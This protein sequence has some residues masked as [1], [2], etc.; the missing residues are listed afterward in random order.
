M[1]L[2][3]RRKAL[4]E[5]VPAEHRAALRS[6]LQQPEPEVVRHRRADRSWVG[7]EPYTPEELEARYHAGRA[8]WA[9][10]LA[11][12]ALVALPD[13]SAEQYRDQVVA[14]RN[15]S[16]NMMNVPHERLP[17][18]SDVSNEDPLPKASVT[19]LAANLQLWCEFNSW[20]VCPTCQ[21]L[22]PR[23]LTPA[24]LDGLLEP[25]CGPK[26][27]RVC[28]GLQKPSVPQHESTPAQLAGLSPA[29]RAALCP[30]EAYYGPEVRARDRFGRGNGYREHSSMVRF[31]WHQLSVED[32]IQELSEENRREATRALRWL[33]RQSGSEKTKSAYGEFYA[34]HHEFLQRTPDATDRQR[35]RWLRFLEREGLECALWPDLFLDRQTC[36]TWVRMQ[37]TSRQ[38]AAHGSTLQERCLSA[39][40]PKRAA[41]HAG[42][43]EMAEEEPETLD[44]VVS[45][46]DASSSTNDSSSS[47]ESEASAPD[48]DDD[49]HEPQRPAVAEGAVPV[50]VPQRPAVAACS[51][52]AAAGFPK[53]RR[54]RAK[55]TDVEEAFGFVRRQI[56]PGLGPQ[57]CTFSTTEPNTAAVLQ[58][59]GTC[60]WCDP[61]ALALLCRNAAGRQSLCRDLRFFSEH[62]IEGPPAA[63]LPPGRDREL[64]VTAFLLPTAFR[65]AAATAHALSTPALALKLAAQLDKCQDAEAKDM[66]EQE[67]LTEQQQA[68]LAEARRQLRDAGP[69]GA[70]FCSGLPAGAGAAAVPCQFGPEGKRA[71]S[72]VPGPCLFCDVT[73]LNEAF[74]NRS[75][76]VVRARYNKLTAAA[77]AMAVDRV[78]EPEFRQ[79]LATGTGQW[80]CGG[81]ADPREDCVFALS[82]AAAAAQTPEKKLRC[83]FCDPESM[84]KKCAKAKGLQQVKRDLLRMGLASRRKALDERVPAEHRAALRSVLQQPEP[85]VVR[86]RRADRSW[87]GTE[88][89]TPEE[90]EARYHAGRAKWAPVL[91]ARALV[92]LPDISAEQYR[93]QVVADRN[94]S[95]NMMNVPHERLPRG[96][97]VSNEDP[98]PKASVTRLAANLQLWCEF[99]SW[100][101]CP[102]CQLLQPRVLTPA[103]LDGLLE[104]WCGPKA[105]RVCR[106]LQK[107]SVPQHESTPAQLAGL[108]PAARAALCPVEAYYGP[109][110]RAKDRFG[111]GN[112]YREHSSM[113]RFSWHQLSVEDR[114]QEL[115]EENRREAT[116]ALRWLLRQSGS[117]KTK[118]AYGE[119]YAEHHEFLQRT[120]D[121]TER[122]RKRWLRFLEREGLECALWPDLFLDRQTC[123]TWVRMQSTS[124][125]VAA[126]GSTLQERYFPLDEA[127]GEDDE[128][129]EDTF[130]STKRAYIALVLSPTLDYSCSYELLHFAYDLNLWTA[131]GA[132]KNKG[133]PIPMRLLMRGHSFSEEFWKDMHRALVDLVRQN[134]FPPVFSTR[135]PLE[136]SFPYHVAVVNTMEKARRGRMLLPVH[137]TLHQTHV[138]TQVGLNFEGGHNKPAERAKKGHEQQ[139]LKLRRPDGGQVKLTSFQRVEFQD[140]KRKAPTQDYHGSGRAH[141]H[142]LEFVGKEN[143]AADLAALQLDLCV[144]ASGSSGDVFVDGYV[145]ASQKDRHGRTPWPLH[146]GE[147]HFDTE[148]GRYVLRHTKQDVEDGIRGYY[149]ATMAVTKC[150][151]DVQLCYD[152]ANYTLYTTAYAPKFSDSMRRE[153]L[154]D[155]ADADSIA[156][157]VLMRYKPCELEMI[158]QLFGAMFRQW[159]VTT[160]SGGKRSFT[161]PVPDNPDQP[162]EVR[163]YQQCSWR[164]EDM[165]MLEFLRKSNNEGGICGWL[166]ELHRKSG[167]T[168]SLAAF[169]NTYK[170][171]GEKIV[172]C[173]MVSRMND[174]Y[175][176]QWLALHVPFRSVID[177]V[178]PNVRLLVPAADK[179]LGMCLACEH[180]VARSHWH[181][182]RLE[183]LMDEDMKLEART[184][185]Y[186]QQVAARLAPHVKKVLAYLEGT[187]VKPADPTAQELRAQQQQ[188]ARKRHQ[189]PIQRRYEQLIDAGEKTIEGRINHGA[190]ARVME[191]DILVLGSTPSLVQAVYTYRSFSAMLEDLGVENALPDVDTLEEALEMYHG[192]NNYETSAQLF[193]VRAFL[194]APVPAPAEADEAPEQATQWNV[195][196]EREETWNHNKI[197]ALEGPPGTGKTTIA[198]YVVELAETYGLKVLWSVYTAQLA[199]R[200]REVFGDRIDINTCHAALGFDEEYHNVANALQGYGLVVIDEF[201]QLQGKHIEHIDKLRSASDRVAAF[202][203][204]GDKCQLAGFG[205]ERVWRTRTWHDAVQATELHQLFRCKDPAFKKILA[206]LRTAKPSETGCRGG[207]SVPDIMRHRRAWHGHYPTVEAVRSILMKHKNTTMLTVSRQG[208]A[209]LNDL[210]L[211]ALYPRRAPLAVI[212]ADIESNPEN[213]NENKELKPVD[214]LACT[215][216][217]LHEGMQV[218]FTR[219]VDK[220]RDYVNGMRGTIRSWD[221]SVQALE[222]RTATGHDVQVF[223]WTDTDLGNKV[224]F[225]IRAG[226]ASTIIKF[227]GAELP[228]VTLWL[229]KPHVPGAAYTGMSRVAYGRDL[230]IGGNLTKDKCPVS[231]SA[232]FPTVCPACQPDIEQRPMLWRRE[233]KSYVVRLCIQLAPSKLWLQVG[234]ELRVWGPLSNSTRFLSS[235]NSP[236]VAV[237]PVSAKLCA[238]WYVKD[239]L[240][241]TPRDLIHDL[242]HVAGRLGRQRGRGRCSSDRSPYFFPWAQAS[243]HGGALDPRSFHPWA[244]A[245]SCGGSSCRGR[246]TFLAGPSGLGA[247]GLTAHGRL[248]SWALVSSCGGALAP[249]PLPLFFP[250][251]HA[252]RHGG[253]P[254]PRSFHPWALASSCGGSWYRGRSTFLAGPSSLGTAGFAAHGRLISW[255]L[256]S[257]SRGSSCHGRCSFISGRMRLDTTGLSIHGRFISWAL[258]SRSD[259]SSCHGRCSCIPGRLRLE[260]AGLSHRGRFRYSFP[261]RL[262]LVAA[263]LRTVVA[264]QPCRRSERLRM[265]VVSPTDASS[266]TSDSSSSEESEASA[267]DPDDDEHE[268]Q[269]PAVAEGAVPVAVPQRPAVAACSAPAAA[270]FPK[271]R[272]LRAKTTDVEE[273]F[274]F[275]RRQIC[276]GLGP[277]ACTFSTTEPN[278][279]AVLQGAGT[280]RWCDPPALALLCRNAAGRQSL[281]RD[282]RFFSEH[283]I[284][285]PPAA[286]LPPGRDR[287]LFVTAFLLPTAFRTA[288]A[289]AHALSTPA[290]ALKLAAQLDKCQDA[291]AKDMAEQEYLTEQ[292]QATLAEARRQLR[293]AGPRGAQFCSGLPAGAGAAAVPCQFGP[294]GKRARTHVPGPCLFCDV[295]KLNEAF[296]NRSA[297]VVRARYNKLTAAAKA[298]AVDRVTEPEFRQWLATGTGQWLCGG[299]A[300][301]R[302]DCVFALSRAAAAAQTP[303]KKLRCLFCDPESMAKKCAKAKG[304]QQVKRDLLRMGLASRRKALDERVPAEHRAALRSVLQQPEPEVVRHRRADRSW[305]GTEPYTPEELEARYH[306]GRAKWAQVLAARA[307]VALP[308][309]SAEQYRDQVVADRNKSL[310][311]MNV[312]HERLPRGSDVSNEDPLPKASVTRL[313]ANLQLWC[314]F[315]SWQVCPTCQLLQPR[316]LTPAGLDGLLEPWCGPK[317]CRVCRGLQK[318]SVPQHESTPAQLAGLS[319]AARAALCP[320]EAY[321]GPEVRARDRFGR[322]NGYREHSSMVRFSWHQLSVEDR[323]QELS[324]ENRREATRA[325]RWLLRQSGS[326]KTKS[327][328][329]EF[330]AEHHEFLQRTPD[331][332]DRQRKHWLRFLEREGLECALWPDLFLDRQTCLTWVRMQSTSRQVAARGSTLQERYFPLDEAAGEDDEPIEDTFASTKRAY[333]ALVLSPTLDYSCSYDLL[334]FAYDLNLWTALGAKKNKGLPIPMR[335]LMR[336]HSFSEEFWKDM[337]RALVDLVRQKGFPPVFSTRSPLE[338]SFPYHVA[339]VN[340]MEKARRG[341]MLL[342]VHETL[343]QTHVLTQVGLNFEGGHS[344]PAERAKKGHEQQLLKLRRPDGGQVKLTSFQRAEFQDG[345]RK[346]PTQD[347]HGSGRAHSHSLE[348]VGK[349]NRAADLAALQLDLCVSASG[350]S[351]DVFVEGY[352]QA[353]QKDRHGRT[354]WPLHEGES[355]F[356]TEAG[357]YVLR[358][359]KQDVEDGIR[360]YY[361]ET[362]AVT[363]CHEDVQLC[364]D[365]ENYTLYTTAYAPKFSDSM[366]RELLNDDADADSIAASVLMRYKPCE[367]EMILQLFGAMFRQW[368]VT[369]VSGGKRSFTVPVP[370]NPDQPREVRLYQQCS[371]RSEDMSMLEFLRKSNNEGGI[372]GWLLELHRKS[373]STASLAAFANTYKMQ[374]EKIVACDMVS[375]MNDKYYGQWLVLHV[376]FR[377]VIDFVQPNVR[378][379]VPAADKYLGMCL[380]CEHA[381]ARSLW[382]TPRLELLMDEDMKLEA[383]TRIYRQQVAARLAPH[384]K[385]V[386]AYLEGTAVKPADPTAQELRAQQQQ[387]ARKRHQLPI[388][389]RYEQLIDAGEKTIEGRINHGAAARVMEGDILVLGS[390]PSLVQAVYTYRSFSAMLEDLGVENAL[391]DVETLEEALE[392]YHGFNN[393][394]TSAQLFGVRAFLLAPVPAPAEADEAPEQATQWNVEQE[395]WAMIVE[396]DI[397]RAAA[398]FSATTERAADEAREETWN[399]NKIRALEGPPGTGKT[400]IARYVVELAETYGL[401][402]LWSVYTAQLASR[403]REVFGDRI[404]INTC[405]AALG[406]DEEYH[407]VANALQG[408]GLVVIDEFSQLQ[409]KHIEHINK[410]RSAS[411]RVAAFVLVGDKCQL[412]GFGTERVWHTHTWRD[413]VQATELHQLFRCKDP[414]F[415]K[416]LACLRTAKPS[417]TGYRGGVSVPDIMRHR[418]A[419]HGHYP[420]VEAVRSILMKH[421]N[422]TMLTVSRQ[423]SATLNDLSLQALYPRRAPLAVISADIESNPENYNENKELKPVWQLACTQLPLHE[424]MQVYFTRNVDKSRDYV[425]GMR[426]TVKSWDASVQAL[427][428]R[429][430][431]GHD[432][433][434]FRWTDTDLGNKVYFPIRAG[435]ASTIIKF[436]GAELPHVTL[437]LDKPHV[438]GAAYT[439]MSRVAYGR[440]LLI[441]GNL[442]KDHFTPAT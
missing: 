404:D 177:F 199:S 120:P 341:R 318:P 361:K 357:R 191:G 333:I 416:I 146:E 344:K 68:T 419:W 30:V 32:R 331:A 248:I 322:G 73:K 204:L 54:L 392:I 119:F 426:G 65:T 382:H 301:P 79:W 17:R 351:G 313:A 321:Y 158:L 340:T 98:L 24:G 277:Q 203:L 256:A 250:W 230:L 151:E 131:L 188:P 76:D 189:I 23:V 196:Q 82:R 244:L 109:E 72:H 202:V 63:R 194:L 285:G 362:M 370:D 233:K 87:V 425:N 441:G 92:A 25:W 434:V 383:R 413:A 200:M 39:M 276:P 13:I 437:W 114:I 46:T 420:T 417:E 74:L 369:T 287:E 31:S 330:Y 201:S 130:A 192:F 427:E 94:K 400:T 110:V 34:E 22:Q 299:L 195:E 421:K 156:A 307:L 165:S 436:A 155:D 141:S 283:N 345:K 8:K 435:Y 33:L 43:E 418:R 44:E 26:A 278:T 215:Q 376:P 64:F 16:L 182:P 335:L 210:S 432:V 431:T 414:A 184:R 121:A 125:Q 265:Q 220:S 293:D 179:Y 368:R 66:A 390:T 317:A 253:A 152:D 292:Q 422:T 258:A 139:L 59:A 440:D 389:R 159:R 371:W 123:L 308:D 127:A 375:R 157:S 337:H 117:E 106:G 225:P 343:H 270:G 168:A 134:G 15:K 303:G 172:A 241:L 122:Q 164:S 378:L 439:G 143:R 11:A 176:G 209:A 48:P 334:H 5:R 262:R 149:P 302:E 218:Y 304:L 1:G 128:P 231:R 346:A 388:Q 391:P 289:T 354:P 257:R 350:S 298:M 288:A 160:V 221:A 252:S 312:P 57:A 347:Y 314:E 327:A 428:V 296:L 55:T 294:E 213:Y 12:R 129:I 77:K 395:R 167:S 216:L 97:D 61:P 171:Q 380:A 18:G 93:D 306:A 286:R 136:W 181:T 245:S 386:L 222:V 148:A 183:L 62:N 99:H 88:P 19:R 228:H 349:E 6:V 217:P 323:I 100:Q 107:P 162:R 310:N 45:P 170:M 348:F 336:G 80:L 355:H 263:G 236:L 430:A 227:A 338:W 86:H 311:M 113:V 394:E 274:G 185:I 138:L 102:T 118:S 397:K 101:V 3:S 324:E 415:K 9:P 69:R 239:F 363:K 291:E 396:E 140:G 52:P 28:R 251:A 78:T 267:P 81:L 35:K 379:L 259:R 42:A 219:N 438:P 51:A 387:P 297:D 305:V 169:A 150:H 85:E 180:A 154:N 7:T 325:L 377:S 353:S 142:S 226:Y 410:L 242:F 235:L 238:E 243:R 269:R 260:A 197:R 247:S 193:G 75:A 37:S 147:S 237:I 49:E 352:V 249:R 412:A 161:V 326:E 56:C 90:L 316:V 384:V 29:A 433:Q 207:V 10:V 358:H 399:H 186:R 205:T 374:G 407:N 261:G 50:A 108:S 58:G 442:T 212:S 423:G 280:C 174:K 254:D 295:T 95:L 91:A 71:R 284:E 234:C 300:D 381:V 89:Y 70:Q 111:R 137:E 126:H 255:A 173:D 309:I 206:C 272:R 373:G 360:G 411:D 124:R 393:Y 429:T 145:Q 342:P 266:S 14:D 83:L 229:D 20:Q 282:L 103:G 223:R 315:N 264:S 320:V 41:A 232:I 408:Y 105:C 40:P 275:V 401:K 365:D 47:E 359:T 332:T 208:S 424:G 271:R 273:A 214:Q 132:K 60:R 112:G 372:C 246:S 175:Y 403:M 211:Q 198:R 366:R 339:V 21:L 328:Y 190:A 240:K 166:L 356:D 96:S 67:Y 398:V 290:L 115:S 279:A 163:L 367:P 38:V 281:C 36:L 135:S 364:Y 187:A 53:R 27:C 133:L 319:P 144:S 402:V 4:D 329:G 385:K 104:P 153:L 84:A 409:G 178:Q 406:L 2:A 405:H 224:Y 116:R 268:P